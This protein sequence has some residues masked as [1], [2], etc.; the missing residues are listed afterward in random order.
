MKNKYTVSLRVTCSDL[1]KYIPNVDGNITTADLEA[2][3]Q[4]M[5]DLI[6][7]Y[8]PINKY[9]EHLDDYSQYADNSNTPYTVK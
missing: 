2:N 1:F 6:E 5:N 8:L 9:F 3:N 7:F 4:K